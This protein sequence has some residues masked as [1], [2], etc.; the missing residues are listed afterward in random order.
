MCEGGEEEERKE[1]RDDKEEERLREYRSHSRKFACG[2]VPLSTL[3]V[4]G[5]S[6]SRT[7]E[8]VSLKHL[9]HS[10]IFLGGEEGGSEEA[11][12]G[13]EEG[14]SDEAGKGEEEGGSDEEGRGEEEGGSE[15]VGKGEEKGGS[16]EEGRGE[17]EGG[18][19][20]AG[21]GEEE[22]GGSEEEER[23]EKK[24]GKQSCFVQTV[25]HCYLL[26]V[27]LKLLVSYWESVEEIV[28]CH[29]CPNLHNTHT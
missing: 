27:A 14:G 22:E 19:D 25:F 20:E 23:G 21:R 1:E 7:D 2:G 8:A 15:E 24:E 17:E 3:V 16:D 6:N 12:R 18:S 4:T 9:Y 13:E 26:Q 28:Q 10:S 11:G 5:Y 29:S